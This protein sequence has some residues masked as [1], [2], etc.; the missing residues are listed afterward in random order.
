MA[1]GLGIS[2]LGVAILGIF[3]PFVTIYIV[4]LSLALAA[5]AGFLGD[6]A[7]PIAATLANLVNIVF[8]S[9]MTWAVLAG[10]NIGGGSFVM[11]TTVIL[12]T[13]PVAAMIFGTIRGKKQTATTE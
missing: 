13:A 8:L 5:I 11:V 1:K 7:F 12:F 9:P 6:K 3:V 4:W 10:E 2:A